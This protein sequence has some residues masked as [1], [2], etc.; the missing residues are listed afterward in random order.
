MLPNKKIIVSLEQISSVRPLTLPFASWLVNC[1][2]D[3]LS[4]ID[5]QRLREALQNNPNTQ[6]VYS[7]RPK[8]DGDKRPDDMVVPSNLASLIVYSDYPVIQG[9][10]RDKIAFQLTDVAEDA[11]F[12]FLLSNIENFYSIHQ[13]VSQFPYEGGFVCKVVIYCPSLCPESCQ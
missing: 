8:R 13:R 10:N 1:F 9:L 11:S 6:P 7:P 12:L 5:L 2:S 3:H 4:S